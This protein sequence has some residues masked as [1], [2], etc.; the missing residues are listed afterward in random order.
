MRGGNK[1]SQMIAGWEDKAQRFAA[2]Q[3]SAP[4]PFKS[5]ARWTPSRRA[6]VVRTSPE[7]QNQPQQNPQLQ[8]QSL[9]SQSIQSGFKTPDAGGKSQAGS[10]FCKSIQQVAHFFLQ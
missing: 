8:S 3:S 5:P 7:Q 6:S 1:V 10:S 4:V 2:A 9:E